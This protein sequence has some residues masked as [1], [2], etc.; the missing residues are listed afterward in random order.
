ILVAPIFN[1][2]GIG[3]FY[4]PKG[5]WTHLLSG[6]VVDGG[7]WLKEKYDYFS[8]PLFV[9]PNTIL[10]IGTSEEN[11]VYDYVDGVTF[12]IYGI[13]DGVKVSRDLVDEKGK[14]VGTV[15]AER[16]G[17]ELKV[18]TKGIN[19]PFQVEVNGQEKVRAE[20]GS[21]EVTINL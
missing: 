8:L 13:E 9:R 3:S 7:T 16:R 18:T 19:K 11:P 12:R 21:T 20:S 17:N 15:V 1:E 10:P 4:L 2:E 6:E 5:K 14:E